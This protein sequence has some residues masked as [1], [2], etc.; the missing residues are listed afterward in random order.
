[1]IFSYRQVTPWL[2]RPIIQVV[3]KS[4]QKFLLSYALI[5]SGSDYCVFNTQTAKILGIRLSAESKN[6]RGVGKELV[7][8]RWGVLTINLAG[9][10]YKIRALFVDTVDVS[11]GILGA[12]GFFD[13]FDVKLSYKKQVIEIQPVS[14][15]N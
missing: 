4:R 7:M 15:P 9:R 6:I 1:M 2:G 5:D 10:S 14:K 11:Q 8:G 13:H 3:L 12:R